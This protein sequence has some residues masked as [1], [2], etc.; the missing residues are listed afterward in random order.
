VNPSDINYPVPS[1]D[2]ATKTIKLLLKSIEKT[3]KSGQASRGKPNG[4]GK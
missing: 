1:N 4:E 2:D 3:V